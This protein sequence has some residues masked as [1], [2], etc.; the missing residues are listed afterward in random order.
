MDKRLKAGA[1][2]LT[3]ESYKPLKY[4]APEE[5]TAAEP[6]E[7]ID[8]GVIILPPVDGHANPEM[9]SYPADYVEYAQERLRAYQ[10]EHGERPAWEVGVDGEA[11]AE[12]DRQA[13]EGQRELQRLADEAAEAMRGK[14]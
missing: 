3:G 5:T 6:Q 2:L 7:G 11:A 9:E 14:L 13:T 8:Y 12:I 4:E 10:R 1:D